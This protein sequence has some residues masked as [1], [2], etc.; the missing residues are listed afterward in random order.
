M[1]HE[2]EVMTK[3]GSSRDEFSYTSYAVETTGELGVES[4][5]LV[6]E[7]IQGSM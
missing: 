1:L 5:K 2:V 6:V 4:S 3:V 7:A